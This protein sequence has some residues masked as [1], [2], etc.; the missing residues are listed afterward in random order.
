MRKGI[1]QTIDE[2]ITGQANTEKSSD[3][4]WIMQG[5]CNRT[6]TSGRNF[7]IRVQK[8]KRPARSDHGASVH[9]SATPALRDNHS[10]RQLA[11]LF[12]RPIAAAA[13]DDNDFRVRR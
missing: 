12:A 7:T 9:L 4:L 11:G 13:I 3:R 5:V 10:G 2:P 1:G 6:K 8:P